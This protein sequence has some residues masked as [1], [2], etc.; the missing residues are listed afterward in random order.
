M[1]HLFSLVFLTVSLNLFSQTTP[2]I[3]SSG[4]VVCDMLTPGEIFILNGNPYMA[5]DRPMLEY[6]RDNAHDLSKVCVSLIN[7][8]SYLFLN[9]LSFN[10]DIGTWD[11]S[12]VTNMARMFE[13]SAFNQDIGN[14]D[15]SNVTDMTRMFEHTPFNQDI[16]SWDVSKVT[17][18]AGMFHLAQDFNKDIGIWD[19]GNV[20]NVS[21]MFSTAWSFKKD[22]GNWDV[23]NVTDMSYMFHNTSFNKDLTNWCVMNFPSQPSGFSLNS[24]LTQSN[25]PVWA[26]CP[27]I[28]V[29]ENEIGSELNAFPNPTANTLYVQAPKNSSLTLVD[30]DGNTL[31]QLTTEAVETSIDM[32][33]FAQ[34]VYMLQIQTG[35]AVETRRIVRK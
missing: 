32:S 1:K 31:T 28:S 9:N 8:M 34:G 15:V 33:S 17:S 22:I 11:V 18:M 35:E 14:W 5:V 7:D 30:M 29:S 24:A 23:S 13:M 16:S 3:D 6:K 21:N 20:K 12:N 10:Q 26:T 2:H 4:C 27:N 25:H 19:V